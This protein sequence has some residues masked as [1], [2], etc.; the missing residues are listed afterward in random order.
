V[1][2]HSSRTVVV[3]PLGTFDDPHFSRLA[4]ESAGRYQTAPPFPHIVFDDF[5]PVQLARTLSAAFPGEDD[6]A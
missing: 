6:I 4:L 5:L 1:S 2:I 3:S